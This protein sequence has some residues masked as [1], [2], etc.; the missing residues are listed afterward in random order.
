MIVPHGL[1]EALIT[2][3]SDAI[4]ATDSAGVIDFWNPGANR[5]FGFRADEAIGRSLE[6]II[7]HNLRTRHWAGFNRVME[8]GVSRYDHGEFLSAPALTKS[9]QRISVEFIIVLLKDGAR[10]SGRNSG[11]SSRC[12]QTIR[13]DAQVEASVRRNYGRSIMPRGCNNQA[14]AFARRTT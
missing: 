2:T 5:I 12:D 8:T 13:R 6:L 7:P 9:G 14:R 10:S 11:N 3:A 4:I 1:I